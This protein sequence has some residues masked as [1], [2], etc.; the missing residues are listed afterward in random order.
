MR[1]GKHK[2]WKAKRKVEK[3]IVEDF[4]TPANIPVVWWKSLKTVRHT[5]KWPP[6][7]QTNQ[8]SLAENE[9][10]PRNMGGIKIQV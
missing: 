4:R 1:V 3:E 7:T 8:A 10:K 9:A 2:K 5:T 6:I